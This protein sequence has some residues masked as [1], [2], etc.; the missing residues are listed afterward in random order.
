MSKTVSVSYGDD[1]FWA[2]DVSLGILLLEA[3]EAARSEDQPEGAADVLGMLN[4][5]AQVG[6]A[7]ELALD[8]ERWTG[9]QRAF[10]HRIIAEAGRRLRDRG[11]M[12]RAEADARYVRAGEPFA[13]R[14]EEHVDGAVLGDLADAMRALVD[15]TLPVPPENH[16]LYG[17]EGGPLTT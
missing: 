4:A 12:T 6:S 16:W 2:Y 9:P 3:I 10:V 13:L 7:W 8:D 11:T 15:G 14:F 17:V 1:W 5:H